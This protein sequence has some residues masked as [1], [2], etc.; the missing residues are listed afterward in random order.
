MKNP[1]KHGHQVTADHLVKSDDEEE[2]DSDIPINMVAVVMLARATQ[3]IAAYPRAS[4]TAEHAIA[5]LRDFAG[6]TDNIA[7]FY[8]DNAPELVAAARA[9]KWRFATATT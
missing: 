1:I 6:P 7:S 3:W 5:A 9:C 4:D 2:E 8:C